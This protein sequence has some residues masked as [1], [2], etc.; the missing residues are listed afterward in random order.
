MNTLEQTRGIEGA[1]GAEYW[2]ALAELCNGGSPHPFRRTRPAEDP[3]NASINYLIG[4]LSRDI[5]A[6]LQHAHL[7][8]GFG[9]LH[10]TRDY[11]D[12]AI[13]DLIEPFRAPLTEGLAVFLFNSNRLRSDMFSND[14]PTTHIHWEGRKALI[15]GYEQAVAKRVNV[16]GRKMKLSWR[17]MMQRQ[18][19][20][21]A[22]A[23][24]QSDPSVFQ[25]Y[26]MKA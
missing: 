2:P 4:I 3:L 7:H 24:R 1:V 17:P 6:A 16:T 23:F 25:P 11:Q 20:D 18:A 8:V 21:L 10:G 12:A 22:K 13:Y 19:L 26:L 15:A 14:G 5:R 9:V